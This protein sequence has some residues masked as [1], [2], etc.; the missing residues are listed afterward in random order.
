MKWIR[1]LLLLAA[2]TFVPRAAAAQ[3]IIATQL[4][5][6]AVLMA[7]G[8]FVPSDDAV[9][10]DLATGED[11]EFEL[12]MR[13][14]MNYVIVGVCDGD[15]TGLDLVLTDAAGQEV[16]PDYALHDVPTI[17]LEGRTGTFVVTVRMATCGSDSCDFGVQVFHR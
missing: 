7:A 8:G 14:G 5:S 2:A 17:A 10:G 15:C 3:D 9:R 13:A 4:D 1:M 6:T 16:I 11:E 12:E